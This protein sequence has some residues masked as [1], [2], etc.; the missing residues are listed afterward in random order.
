MA[1][2]IVSL[3]REV[4]ELRESFALDES[5]G[6]ETIPGWDSLGTLK[7]VTAAEEKFGVEF[8]LEDIAELLTIADLRRIIEKTMRT[9]NAALDEK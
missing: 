4:F 6:P 7:L 8:Q 9:E 3:V 1:E 5:A 2:P